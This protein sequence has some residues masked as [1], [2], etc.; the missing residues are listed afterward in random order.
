VGK[1]TLLKKIIKNLLKTAVK[2]Q[3]IFYYSLDLERHPEDILRI[4][5][6]FP[7]FSRSSKNREIDTILILE[8]QEVPVEIRYQGKIVPFDY[9]TLKRVFQRGIVITRKD[10]F[11]N[12]QVIDI[13]ACFF[14]YLLGGG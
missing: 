11:I 13:P 3:S 5:Q 14:L 7:E 10:F 9:I 2:P 12:D 8:D 1:T 4:F 6:Q